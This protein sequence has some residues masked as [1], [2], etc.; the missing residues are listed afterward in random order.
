MC[1]ETWLIK[2]KAWLNFLKTCCLVLTRDLVLK[3]F[4][5]YQGSKRGQNS[6]II[7]SDIVFV[8]LAASMSSDCCF[9]VICRSIFADTKYRFSKTRPAHFGLKAEQNS[10]R[11]VEFR[12][13]LGKKKSL[14]RFSECLPSEED[15]SVAGDKSRRFGKFPFVL[16]HIR[17]ILAKKSK[18]FAENQGNS[19]SVLKH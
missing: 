5:I 8:T 10:S 7:G 17:A 3:L 9:V 16:A 19:L 6:S 12:R 4:G 1:F 14:W 2:L 13:K 15:E 11:V 18:I